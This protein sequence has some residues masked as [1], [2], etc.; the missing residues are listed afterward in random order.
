MN[1]N[2][3]SDSEISSTTST[4]RVNRPD[5]QDMIEK[6]ENPNN[7]EIYEEM[8]HPLVTVEFLNI[9]IKIDSNTAINNYSKYLKITNLLL[10]ILTTPQI[11]KK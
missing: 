11:K 7:Y 3:E 4:P 6:F 2:R 10:I 1:Q 9:L 5:Y 8:Q